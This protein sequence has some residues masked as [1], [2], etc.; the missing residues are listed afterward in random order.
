MAHLYIKDTVIS[1]RRLPLPGRVVVMGRSLDVDVP[2]PHV[3]VSRRH[4]LIEV[5]DSGFLLSDL[6]S[7]NGTFVDGTRLAEGERREIS[8]DTPFRVGEVVFRV[9]ADEKVGGPPPEPAR[10]VAPAPAPSPAAPVVNVTAA[11][12]ARS[13]AAP[14]RPKTRSKPSA[15]LR[16]TKRREREMAM[17]WLG[18]LVTVALVGL[19]AVFLV[20]I[21]GMTGGNST[22]DEASAATETV[23]EKDEI[24]EVVPLKLPGQE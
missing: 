10:T 12:K 21:V 11:P 24:R 6:G 3:S 7:S 19:A 1:E 9:C 16:G 4:A 14:G 13:T 22:P 8:Y 15:A 20:R 23:P 17:K 18:V 5:S 2:V